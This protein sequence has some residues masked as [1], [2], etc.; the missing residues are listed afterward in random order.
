MFR[1]CWHLCYDH[2]LMLLSFITPGVNGLCWFIF[3]L[4]APV[5]K[6]PEGCYYPQ[7]TNITVSGWKDCCLVIPLISEKSCRSNTLVASRRSPWMGVISNPQPSRTQ[8]TPCNFH[9]A[10]CHFFF[11]FH[12]TVFPFDQH[13]NSRGNDGTVSNS[14]I[15][16]TDTS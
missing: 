1:L 12:V 16:T 5:S 6:K 10:S 9:P 3:N 4:Q 7:I 2:T 11:F 13:M 15:I 14:N 8:T